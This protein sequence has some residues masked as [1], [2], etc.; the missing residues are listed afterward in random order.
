M[1]GNLAPSSEENCEVFSEDFSVKSAGFCR[2]DNSGY[3]SRVEEFPERVWPQVIFETESFEKMDF[4]FKLSETIRLAS[5]NFQITNALMYHPTK[6][7][8]GAF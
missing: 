6:E 4:G 1:G 2:N 3:C 5:A 8:L 7:I